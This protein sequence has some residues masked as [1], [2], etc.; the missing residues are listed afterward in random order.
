MRNLNQNEIN[1]VAGGGL[2]EDFKEAV[3]ELI[4]RLVDMAKPSEDE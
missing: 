4:D 3:G 1:A 2:W